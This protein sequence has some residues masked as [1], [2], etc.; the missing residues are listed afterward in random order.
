VALKYFLSVLI[1]IIGYV[2]ISNA[3]SLPPILERAAAEKQELILFSLSNKSILPLSDLPNNFASAGVSFVKKKDQLLMLPQG[4]GRVYRLDGPS[5]ARRW[6]RIDST[7]FTGYN[8][9]FYPFVL[10][11]VLYSFGGHG[12]WYTNGNLRFYNETGHEWNAKLLSE[13]IPWS[14]YAHAEAFLHLD[15]AGKKLTIRASGV[16]EN[17]ML[18]YAKDTVHRQNIYQL[19]IPSGE[20]TKLGNAKDTAFSMMAIIPWGLLVNQTTVVDFTNNRYLEFNERLSA[21][22]LG[23]TSNSTQDNALFLSFA[24]DSTLYFGNLTDPYD[25]LVISRADLID[26]GVPIFTKE[27]KASFLNLKDTQSIIILLLVI[28]CLT[29]AFLYWKKIRPQPMLASINLPN[30]ESPAVAKP[31]TETEKTVSFRSTRI[32]DLL[33]ERE[34]SLLAFIYKHSADERLTSIE[35]INKVIGVANRSNEIQKRMR[36]DIIGSVNQK[37][38]IITKDKKPVIDK[39]RSE[40]DKRSFE[41]FIQPIHME[42]VEKVLGKK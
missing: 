35:E 20:W 10:D 33:E 5:G 29:L 34:R 28:V 21:K 13:S 15:T 31:D 36:S 25:S 9:G 38:N 1:F 6:T 8:F 4:T 17:N 27:E 22:I 26:T 3:Q 32:L 18:K 30:P 11:G 40:F 42:L 7:F 24:I 16:S 2:P 37:L 14:W 23:L 19:D 12:L 41:Y 39:Q